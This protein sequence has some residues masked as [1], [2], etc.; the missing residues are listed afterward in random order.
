[1]PA[2]VLYPDPR[3]R[4]AS[5]KIQTFDSSLQLLAREMYDIMARADGIGL[6]AAQVGTLIRLLIV[7]EDDE[8]Q[9]SVFCN[10]VITYFSKKKTAIEEG[11]LSIPGVMGFVERSAKIRLTYQDLAGAPHQEKAGGLRA[12]VLQHEIDH[13]NGILIL[14]RTIQITKGGNLVQTNHGAA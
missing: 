2:L 8:R 5:K 12:I 3:L 1:M 4:L 10:P 14:D 11:C 9:Y 6:A 13:L 7:R